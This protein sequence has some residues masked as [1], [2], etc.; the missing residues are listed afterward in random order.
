[1]WKIANPPTSGI[2][3]CCT[4]L[5][6]RITRNFDDDDPADDE[7]LIDDPPP[8]LDEDVPTAM[9]QFAWAY[10]KGLGGLVMGVMDGVARGTGGD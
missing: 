7:D 10:A 3:V 2:Q 5:P 4:Y 9:L 6:I 1:M 8:G